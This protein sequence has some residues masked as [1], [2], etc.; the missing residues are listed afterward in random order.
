MGNGG[1][2]VIGWMIYNGYLGDKFLEHAKL[3]VESAK[4]VGVELVPVPS[5]DVLVV[6]NESD[7]YIWQATTYMQ[8]DF[9]LYWDKDLYLARELQRL[10]LPMFNTVDAIAQCIDKATTRQILSRASIKMPTT[11]LAP[12]IYT[13]PGVTNW[14]TFEPVIE[15]IGFPMVIKENFGSFGAQVYLVHDRESMKKQI[16]AIGDR[17]FLMQ[18]F[19]AA[20][21]GVDARL[22]VVGDQVVAA[23]KRTST[24]DFRANMTQG[25]T[26]KRYEPS[27]E[28]IDLVVKAAKALGADFA[29]VDLL[30][31]KDLEPIVCEV[32]AN[33]HIVNLLA[34]TGI[35][36]ADAMMQH[37][38][39]VVRCTKG[40]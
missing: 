13:Y 1:K 14:A 27:Q 39:D 6:T 16:E 15:H 28:E 4:R 19:I 22:Q 38:V 5:T 33:A 8:P 29:G 12:K 25:A 7:S 31:S 35:N 37:I 40:R 17:P 18:E 20:S 10:N 21:S 24:T 26:A 32:N 34:C 23:M 36:A 2:V 9:L 3:F 30:F 11:F